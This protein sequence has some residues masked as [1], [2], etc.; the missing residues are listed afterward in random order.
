M[1]FALLAWLTWHGL[2]G[3]FRARRGQREAV[4]LGKV[5]ATDEG[6]GASVASCLRCAIAGRGMPACGRRQRRRVVVIIESSPNNLDLRQGTDAQ[7]E[8]VGG[9]DLRCAGEEG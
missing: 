1:A 9:A 7:S 5:S 6:S 4:V 8:R 3:M 2:P